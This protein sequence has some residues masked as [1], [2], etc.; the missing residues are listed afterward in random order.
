MPKFDH[1]LLSFELFVKVQISGIF[2][3]WILIDYTW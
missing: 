2:Q 3:L 1:V